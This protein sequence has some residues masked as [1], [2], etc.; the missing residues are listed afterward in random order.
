MKQLETDHHAENGPRQ[1]LD[2]RSRRPLPDEGAHAA[3]DLASSDR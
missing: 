1:P 2:G 3:V